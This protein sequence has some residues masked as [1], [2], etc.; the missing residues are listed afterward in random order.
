[1]RFVTFLILLA[2]S[3]CRSESDSIETSP[4]PTES[5]NLEHVEASV[6][7]LQGASREQIVSRLV[8]IA[9]G[10]IHGGIE[11]ERALQ[12]LAVRLDRRISIRCEAGSLSCSLQKK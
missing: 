5:Q 6:L 8:E 2:F 3:G 4:S 9:Q 7:S 10:D 11:P 12:S 1:M